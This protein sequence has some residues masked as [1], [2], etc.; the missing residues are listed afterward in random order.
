MQDSTIPLPKSASQAEEVARLQ[1]QITTLEELLQ[2]Y[3]QSATEQEQRLQGAL[4]TLQERAQQLEHAQQALQTLQA[5]LDSMGD[6]VI[7]INEEGQ[8]LFSN[9]A[10]RELLGGNP[11][12]RS[13]PTQS[14]AYSFHNWIQAHKILRP[15]GISPYP[16][17]ELPLALAIRGESVDT[18]QMWVTTRKTNSSQWLSVNARP[19]KAD[20]QITGA[21]A[22]FSDI[23]QN[24]LFEQALQYSSQEAQRQAELLEETLQQLKQAQAQLIQSEKMTS[25]GQTVAGI[26]HEIN[27][28]VS[29]IH[30]N[31]PHTRQAFQ[32]LLDLISLFQTTY[33]TPTAEIAEAIEEIDLAFLAKD[34]PTMLASMQAGTKRIREIVKSLRL[35]SRLD[36]ADIKAVNVHAGIDS[37][38]MILRSQL[39]ADVD[40]PAIQVHKLYGDLPL[41][42]CYAAQLNQV[43]VNVLANAVDALSHQAQSPQ[44]TIRTKITEGFAVIEIS[45]NGIGIPEHI[46]S[47]IFDPFFTT[48]PVG[49]GTGL[50]LSIC[51]KII[52]ETHQGRLECMSEEGQST[53]VIIKLP[54]NPQLVT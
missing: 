24:K 12:N 41:I 49:K 26:A 14:F 3:E 6:A 22:V 46:S 52:V 28:P 45:D 11:S 42:E 13:G 9:P 15:D 17:D 4:Q 35:F 44:I 37:A 27:N 36:E 32:D 8:T 34:I 43:F 53:E 29:F 2:I 54:L 31:L 40:R 51:Y 7:V 16:A 20:N 33:P 10:A 39:E 21:V 23:T 25:L 38:L 18:A 50:G 5:I 30:G 48:K 47:K 19:L 1:A